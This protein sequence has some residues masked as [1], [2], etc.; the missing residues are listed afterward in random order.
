ML[1]STQVVYV[2]SVYEPKQALFVIVWE[3]RRLDFNSRS[4]EILEI[5]EKDTI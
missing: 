3:T 1:N 5:L 2:C 4:V